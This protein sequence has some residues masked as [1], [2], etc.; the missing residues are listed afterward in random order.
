MSSEEILRMFTD[1]PE[2]LSIARGAIQRGK[3]LWMVDAETGNGD[4]GVFKS[5]TRPL[6]DGTVHASSALCAL[7]GVPSGQL[8]IMPAQHIQA[9]PIADLLGGGKA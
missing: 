3:T 9:P 4:V 5:K 6:E 8:W 1:D 2:Y 7:F